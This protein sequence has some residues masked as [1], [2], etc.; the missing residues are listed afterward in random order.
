MKRIAGACALLLLCVLPLV[1]GEIPAVAPEASV[2]S[3]PLCSMTGMTAIG[4]PMPM[5][6]G[7]IPPPCI[8]YTDCPVGPPAQCPNVNESSNCWYSPGCW[9]DCGQDGFVFCEGR[10]TDPECMIW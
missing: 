2:A 8:G 6:K 10:Q 7:Y 1:A 5:F 3:S 9:V 4:V